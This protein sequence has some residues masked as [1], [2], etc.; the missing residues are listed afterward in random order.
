M[1]A[2][3]GF[4]LIELLIVIGIIGVLASI[5]L[6]AMGGARSKARDAVRQADMRQI[7]SAMEMYY[8][9]EGSDAYLKSAAIP[10]N[11]GTYLAAFPTDPKTKN[12]YGWVDNTG[13]DQKFCVYATMENKGSCSTA[14]YFAASYKGTA[15]ACNITS[16]T[17]ACP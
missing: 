3:K 5:V 7:A 8:G 1:K 10:G 13:D 17:L 14:R 11:I 2:K 15:E 4:T 16:W 9:A 12:S 6:V